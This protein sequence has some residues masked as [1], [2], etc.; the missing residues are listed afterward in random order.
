MR[1]EKFVGARR[2]YR[3]VNLICNCVPYHKRELVSAPDPNQP[4][5]GSFPIRAGVGLGLGPRLV[6][7][8]CHR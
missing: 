2:Q 7:F 6:N 5:R 8:W 3:T 4:Q 1:D